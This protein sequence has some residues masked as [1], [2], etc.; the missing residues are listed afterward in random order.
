MNP[1]DL[2]I[3]TR[4]N[5]G[6]DCKATGQRVERDLD[7]SGENF[8]DLG[9]SLAE[10]LLERRSPVLVH[11]LGGNQQLDQLPLGRWKIAKPVGRI[12]EAIPVPDAVKLQRGM[13]PAHESDVALDRPARHFE[14]P[15]RVRALGHARRLTAESI[16]WSR[17]RAVRV[18]TRIGA[19]SQFGSVGSKQDLPLPLRPSKY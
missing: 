6:Q 17:S 7:R 8:G 14:F 11:H 10:I 16:A 5:A 15:G 9:Q 2:G 12:G 3:V 1:E 19:P 4:L 13:K 18:D